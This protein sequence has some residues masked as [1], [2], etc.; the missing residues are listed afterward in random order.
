MRHVITDPR[1]ISQAD[2][3]ERHWNYEWMGNSFVMIYVSAIT[4][5][6]TNPD[7]SLTNIWS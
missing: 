1:I 2:W 4:Y 6:Y 7:V 3:L 5:T